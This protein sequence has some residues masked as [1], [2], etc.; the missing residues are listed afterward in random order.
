MVLVIQKTSL[1]KNGGEGVSKPYPRCEFF[2]WLLK[3]QQNLSSWIS[4]AGNPPKES[5]DTIKP[6]LKGGEFK[7]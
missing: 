5:D 7:P 3:P 1:K 6:G 4:E 2:V